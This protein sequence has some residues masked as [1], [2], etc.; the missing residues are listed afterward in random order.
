V[1][2]R[3]PRRRRQDEDFPSEEGVGFFVRLH[4]RWPDNWR[5]LI[6]DLTRFWH[7]GPQDAWG[8]TGT[9]LLWWSDQASRIVARERE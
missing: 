8:L 5:D 1:R 6:A 7:W 3:A 2:G 9:Q 4:R